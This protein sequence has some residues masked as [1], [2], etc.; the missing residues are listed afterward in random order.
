MKEKIQKECYRQIR[1]ALQ[2]GLNVESKLEII[3]TLAVEVVT[4]SFNIISWN[5]ADIR[6]IDRKVRK[7][8]ASNRMH[9]P[10]ADV[11]RIYVPKR[12]MRRGIINLEICFKTT[13]IGGK[14]QLKRAESLN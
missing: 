12:E 6:R 9:S 13:T 3:N 7:L 1:S 8:L 4:Y 10:K 2:T 11:N 5:F 14:K